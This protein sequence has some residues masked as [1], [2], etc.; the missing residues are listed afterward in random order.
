MTS[1]LKAQGLYRAINGRFARIL[2]KEKEKILLQ[3]KER[4]GDSPD[5]K[6]DEEE[7]DLTPIMK[8]DAG[9]SSFIMGYCSQGPLGHILG[10]ETTQEQWD[11]LK[12]LYAPLGL[13]QLEAKSTAF[14]NYEPRQNA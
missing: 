11:K 4:Q 13:H 12:S 2:R 14:V 5:D 8:R 3:E 9:A 1:A 10:L 7:D 6:E